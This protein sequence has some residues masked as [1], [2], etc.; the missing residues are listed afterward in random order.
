M[1]GHIKSI[2]MSGLGTHLAHAIASLRLEEV[3]ASRPFRLLAA[4]TSSIAQVPLFLSPVAAFSIYQAVPSSK[5][6]VLDAQRLFAA[7]SVIV[8]VTQPLFSMFESVFDF[9]AAMAAFERIETF[10]VESTKEDYREFVTEAEAEVGNH[11][12]PVSAAAQSNDIGAGDIE[13]RGLRESGSPMA[14]VSSVSKN[15]SL[16]AIDIRNADFCWSPDRPIL[17]D[18]SLSVPSGQLAMLLGPV[19]SGKTTLLKALL[20][21]ASSSNPAGTVRLSSTS[22]SWCDQSPWI[23]NQTIKDN[24]VG[25]SPFRQSLYDR[26]IAACELES[27]FSQLAQGD[28]TVV[29]SKGFALSGGQKQRVSLA[30]SVYAQPRIAVLDDVFSGLDGSTARKVFANLFQREEGLLRQWGTTIVLATQSGEPARPHRIQ[31]TLPASLIA[32]DF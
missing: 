2:K 32:F 3:S 29:G 16:P 28:M 18:V 13:L 20:G 8:L 30:R 6:G 9:S 19:A 15:A 11:S 4:V 27:D 1:L 22:L 14:L 7:L 31:L 24:I 26:V 21:E 10:L 12:P 17:T 5:D 23:T 25:Y